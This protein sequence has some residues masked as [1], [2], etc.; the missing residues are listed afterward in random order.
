MEGLFGTRTL[1]QVGFIVRDVEQAKRKWA[2][3]LGIEVPPTFDGGR[4][5]I[6][7]TTYRGAPA[8]YANCL[9]AFLKTGSDD[10]EIELIEPNE[11]PS[12]WREFLDTHGEGIHHLAFRVKDS[13][14][15]VQLARENGMQPVQRG[16]YGDGGGE[17]N[18]LEAP[19]LHC[20]IETLESYGK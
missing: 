12:T 8:P 11:H 14:K 15:M 3:F 10:L 17:Y 18:Y 20:L 4:Y 1:A 9:M 6:T 13:E 7:G 16:L 19:E 5:E 2:A